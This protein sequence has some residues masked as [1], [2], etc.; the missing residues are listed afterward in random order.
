MHLVEKPM[1]LG[2]NIVDFPLHCRIFFFGR[3]R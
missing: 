1:D 3:R 2:G